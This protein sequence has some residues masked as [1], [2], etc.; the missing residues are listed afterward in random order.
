MMQEMVIEKTPQVGVVHFRAETQREICE[1]FVRLQEFYESPFDDIRG[2]FFRLADFMKR[3]TE[4]GVTRSKKPGKD[5]WSLYDWHGFNVP[6]HVVE[7]FFSK[8]DAWDRFI[9][10]E[11]IYQE[12][13]GFSAYYL[14]GSHVDKKDGDEDALKHELVHAS[15]YLD[16]VYCERVNHYVAEFKVTPPGRQ[17]VALLKSW[18][19]SDG[20]MND[21]I[22]AYLATTPERW[23]LK[24]TKDPVLARALWGGRREFRTL[25]DTFRTQ[26]WL[27]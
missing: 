15:Y 7:D 24:E 26:R 1:T 22:N 14:I 13:R 11:K 9:G 19:Y 21:E 8:F 2:H 4:A 3:Y 18:G 12:T 17:L 5:F 27:R 16:P 25:A 23:W 6:G 10:E 20:T